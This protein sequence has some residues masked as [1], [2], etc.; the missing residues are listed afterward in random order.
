M[1]H[2]STTDDDA[3]P[4]PRPGSWVALEAR[5]GRLERQYD[6][7]SGTVTTMAVDV[8]VT[9][10]KLDGVDV[11]LAGLGA[12]VRKIAE[13]IQNSVA[14]PMTTPAGRVLVTALTD[15]R[16]DADKIHKDLATSVEDLKGEFAS[17]KAEA[18]K[19]RVWIATATG[20]ITVIVFLINLLAPYIQH[21]IG[22]PLP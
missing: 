3:T 7:L 2:M 15:H 12:D 17:V 18:M 9:R 5:V 20:A 8:A 21:F 16:E 22:A 1:A 19:N 13:G 14:D 6:Q 10:S 4:A 11:S